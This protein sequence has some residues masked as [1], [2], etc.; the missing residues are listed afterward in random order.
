M[1]ARLLACVFAR[2]CR[3]LRL[4]A[5][6]ASVCVCTF[7]NQGLREC[8]HFARACERLR[9]CMR[10]RVVGMHALSCARPCVCGSVSAGVCVHFYSGAQ[11]C[12]VIGV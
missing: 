12:P 5:L 7:E 11:P 1:C 4:Y 6:A 2:V 9:V 8:R 3:R 10:A